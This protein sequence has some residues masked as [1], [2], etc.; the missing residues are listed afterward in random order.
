MSGLGLGPGPGPGPGQMVFD[1]DV[2]MR[3]R[4]AAQ[5][6]SGAPLT[7]TADYYTPAELEAAFGRYVAED[8]RF[9]SYVDSH[10]RVSSATLKPFEAGA[11]SMELFLA[12]GACDLP[13]HTP[14][15]EGE[16]A[17]R[18]VYQANCTSCRWDSIHPDENEAVE[19]WHDH[20]LPAGETCRWC[21]RRRLSPAGT[22]SEVT[23]EGGGL[24]P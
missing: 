14:H 22:W 19:A 13:Q 1:L 18:C 24:G 11:H 23:R 10:L 2:L 3:E 5:G 12:D 7:Y 8:G 15:A 9:A 16:L 4:V 17:G 20:A 6:W 21:R